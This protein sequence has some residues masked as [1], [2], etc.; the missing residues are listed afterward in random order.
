MADRLR[1]A[2]VISHQT[3]EEN[4]SCV[5]FPASVDWRD[6]LSSVTVQ[7]ASLL[8]WELL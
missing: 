6:A 3:D 1:S 7:S 4:N 2:E 8:L 5:L